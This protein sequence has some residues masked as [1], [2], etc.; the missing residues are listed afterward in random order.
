MKKN[1]GR[2]DRWIRIVLGVALLLFAWLGQGNLRWLGLIGIIP[3]VTALIG[4]CP[5]YALLKISTNKSDAK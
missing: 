1:I 5:L 4:Y 3:V 2:T